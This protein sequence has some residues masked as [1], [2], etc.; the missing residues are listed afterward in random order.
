MWLLEKAGYRVGAAEPRS[1]W[2]PS[3]P[4]PKH[5]A[6][7]PLARACPNVLTPDR[8]PQFCIPP[9]LPDP[10]AAEPHG[11]RATGGRGL[12][13]ACSLPHLAGREGWAFLP[14]SPHTR[15]R[16]SLFHPPPPPA[17]AGGLPP[18]PSRL[19]VSAPD[20]RLCRAP[21]SDTASS[22]D[23]SPFGSPRPGP[24]RPRPPRPRSLSPEEASSAD[25]SPPAPPLFHLDFLCCRLRPTKESVLRL[26]PRGGQLRLSAEYQ[27][28][29]GRLRLRLV[30]AEG[31]PPSR[32]GPG[33]GGGG[34]GCCVV[35]RL[36]PRARP[37]GQRSRVVKCSANPIF[38]EDFFFDGL[39]PPDLAAHSLRAK[40]LDRGAG[41][42]RDVLLG[43]CEA[44]L[45]ALLPPLGGGLVPGA[46][47]APAHLS[48]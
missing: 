45:I 7:C 20:L 31:L 12:P 38:N 47:L 11:G 8:I 36:R 40:V 17:P 6:P 2:A 35:L 23:S 26:E 30:S 19:H 22:P 29:P 39:G 37:R 16:E 15:R 3:S 18:A 28:W 48:L 13:A 1:R 10:R 24:D 42:R 46:S 14:E 5:R 43:E 4:F 25:T 33:S 9:R 44:P 41:F 27:A 21:D 34:G 32:A